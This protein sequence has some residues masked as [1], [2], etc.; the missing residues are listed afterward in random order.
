[1][2]QHWLFHQPP[3]VEDGGLNGVF[4][5]PSLDESVHLEIVIEPTLSQRHFVLTLQVT[6]SLVICFQSLNIDL[7]KGPLNEVASCDH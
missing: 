4:I 7:E 1:M 2:S 3:L 5:K 6:T